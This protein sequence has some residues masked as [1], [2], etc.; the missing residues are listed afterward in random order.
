MARGAH[1]KK[2]GILD[3][4]SFKAKSGKNYKATHSGDES[5]E[6]A[7]SPKKKKKKSKGAALAGSIIKAIL[8]LFVCFMLISPLKG[9][10]LG[11]DGFIGA[12]KAQKIAIADSGVAGGK[13]SK[14]DTDMIQIDDDFCY[15]VQF[16]GS[17]TDYRY[18]ID[19]ETGDIIAQVFYHT[20]G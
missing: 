1:E 9:C 4:I 18:I 5:P 6:A 20:D 16:T 12:E 3:R 13:V 19:A 7:V 15:K 17:V 2:L 8:F 14:L 11:G 10:V